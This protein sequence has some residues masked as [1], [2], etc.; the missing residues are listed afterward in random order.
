MECLISFRSLCS[1]RTIS[2]L[3]L[4]Q[5]TSIIKNQVLPERKHSIVPLVRLLKAV[6]TN[7]CVHM[8]VYMMYVCMYVCMHVC[9]YVY[10]YVCVHICMYGLMYECVQELCGYVYACTCVSLCVC[11][12]VCLCICVCISINLFLQNTKRS[13]EKLPDFQ[14]EML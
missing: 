11:V 6:R 2:R 5:F 3:N 1:L 14:N 13:C 9:T 8:Y 10:M 12:C 4:I 7:G